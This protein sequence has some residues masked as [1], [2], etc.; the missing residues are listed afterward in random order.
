[1][2]S[3]SSDPSFAYIIPI[4]W[5]QVTLGWSLISASIPSFRAFIKPLE[6]ANYGGTNVSTASGQLY[7]QY[8][9][10]YLMMGPERSDASTSGGKH[11]RNIMKL[12]PE[13]PQVTSRVESV[14]EEQRSVRSNDSR[15]DI[16]RKG[17][18]WRVDYDERVV[19]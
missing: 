14:P 13:K 4:A 6:D 8:T 15:E 10:A 5:Q 9:G 19:E 18:G 2:A 17:T 12:R 3:Q 7:S 16:I 11:K 1:M